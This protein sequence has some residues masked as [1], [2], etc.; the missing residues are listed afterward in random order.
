MNV[1]RPLLVVV[2]VIIVL[3]VIAC[4]AGVIRGR[5][6]AGR[7]KQTPSVQFDGFGDSKVPSRDVA[8]VGSGCDRSG[9]VITIT[10]TCLLIADP[11]S[12]R[13]R[14]LHLD[15]TSGSVKAVVA[16]QIRGETRTSDPNPDPTDPIEVSVSGTSPVRVTLNCGS[17][18]VRIA[19]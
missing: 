8:V 19:Q 5:M 16:Q 13:P 4:G 17:C 10:T 7:P 6:D 2:V 1:P 9:A 15:V 11:Q 3:G 18:Q 14:T 12:I